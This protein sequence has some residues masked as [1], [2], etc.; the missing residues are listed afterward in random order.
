MSSFERFEIQAEG[1]AINAKGLS[2]FA[3]VNGTTETCFYA[4]SLAHTTVHFFMVQKKISISSN[5]HTLALVSVPGVEAQQAR[6]S[7]SGQEG[8]GEHHPM[9]IPPCVV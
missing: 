3:Q 5:D 8:G 4:L 6:R 1:V 2:S 7:H 9:P